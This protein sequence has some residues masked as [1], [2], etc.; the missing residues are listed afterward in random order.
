[1]ANQPPRSGGSTNKDDDSW[2]KL[3]SD[4]FGIQFG[5]APDDDDDDF[6]LT[7]DEPAV[8]VPVVAAPTGLAAVEPVPQASIEEPDLSFPED[9]DVVAPPV[10]KPERK[11]EP[12]PVKRAESIVAAAPKTDDEEEEEVEEVETADVRGDKRDESEKDI[13]DLLETWNWDEPNRDASRV[14]SA[15]DSQSSGSR[16]SGGRPSGGGRGDDRGPRRERSRDRGADRSADRPARPRDTEAAA[17]KEIPPAGEVRPARREDRPRRAESADRDRQRT[18]RPGSERPAGERPASERPAPE[19]RPARSPDDSERRPPARQ[20]ERPVSAGRSDDDFAS[21]IDESAARAK[22]PVERPRRPAPPARRPPA[23]RVLEAVEESDEFEGDLFVE[24]ET[25]EVKGDA[26]DLGADAPAVG[27]EEP[28]RRRRRRRRGGRP[29]REDGTRE[30]ADPD[31]L[32]EAAESDESSDDE[33][34]SVAPGAATEDSADEDSADE[35][36][37]GDREARPPRR[38][39]R[40]VRRRPD[41][42]AARPAVAADDAREIDDS[43]ESDEADEVAVTNIE[44]SDD[45]RFEDDEEAPVPVSYEGIPSW[46]EAISYLQRRPRE[47]RPRGEGSPRGRGGPNRR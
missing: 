30:S 18:E 10:R 15:D 46:E 32:A 2:G 17:A 40:R 21:G 43:E 6:D 29:R 11:I 22:P 7:D 12:K 26:G 16:P 19:R 9:D 36:S 41:E 3:A 23:P 8:T 47:S 33:F 25:D 35:E 38:R 14:R 1:M 44:P 45:E 5:G 42:A 28:R 20:A 31:E 4:L 39:R 34:A 37:N 27:N 13:W 24:P